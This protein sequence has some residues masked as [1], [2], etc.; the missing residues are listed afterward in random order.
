MGCY[1]SQ[2]GGMESPLMEA[3]MSPSDSRMSVKVREPSGTGGG[4][5]ACGRRGG[6]QHD[7]VHKMLFPPEGADPHPLFPFSI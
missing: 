1:H 7:N 6:I 2:L 5:G 3:K 4:S